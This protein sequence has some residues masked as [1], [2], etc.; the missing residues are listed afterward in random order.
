VLLADSE[1]DI[2]PL[3]AIFFIFGLPV[4]GWLSMRYLAHRE[5]MEMIRAGFDPTGAKGFRAWQAQQAPP[6]QYAPPPGPPPQYFMYNES[7]QIALR[8]A[9]VI[10]AVGLALTIGLSFIGWDD[11]RLRLG[12]WLLGGL[13]PLFVGLAQVFSAL[14]AGATLRPY[15]AQ[16]GRQHPGAM[17]PPPPSA[18]DQPSGQ[19]AGWAER[20]AGS[21]TYRPGATPEL[22]PPT[23]PAERDR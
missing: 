7:A 13:V 14:A 12:P 4:L 5:R 9:I 22:R 3:A 18:S 15:Q 17:P 23:P 6:P 10:V 8:K 2:I 16:F 19:A 11:G 20:P 21:Y 1:S